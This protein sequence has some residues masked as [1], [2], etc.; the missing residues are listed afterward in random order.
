MTKL[1]SLSDAR[2][3]KD[4]GSP[5]L[6]NWLETRISSH[7][8]YM[9]LFVPVLV[10]KSVMRMGDQQ[11][12]FPQSGYHNHNHDQEL[13]ECLQGRRSAS[14]KCRSSLRSQVNVSAW[15]NVT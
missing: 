10:Y 11:T 7:R 3:P 8:M 1:A 14:W 12:I 5:R 2:F 15:G 13:Q 4:E 6:Y 9:I